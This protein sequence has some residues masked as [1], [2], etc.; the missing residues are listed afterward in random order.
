MPVVL[1]GGKTK[2]EE[3]FAAIRRSI[4][5]FLMR[6]RDRRFI[7]AA[8]REAEKSTVKYQHG[9]IICKKKTI[10]ASGHNKIKT[11]PQCR[12]AYKFLH[13]EE[14]ALIRAGE[15]A[16]GADIYIVRIRSDG[17]G[18]SRPCN[19]CTVALQE[20]GI[21]NVYYTTDNGGMEKL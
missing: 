20:A 5:F 4:S 6:A 11:H 1:A 3:P 8:T 13:A 15:S 2:E 21:R 19:I 18:L 7:D 17:F 9:A 14:D 12:Q 10:I 16:K